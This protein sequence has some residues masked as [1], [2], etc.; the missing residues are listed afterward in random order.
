MKI[1]GF[2]H[3]EKMNIP[4][5]HD[6][7]SIIEG[8]I[9]TLKNQLADLQKR[10]NDLEK[11]LTTINNAVDTKPRKPEHSKSDT[12]ML[13]K[14]LFL[15]KEQLKRVTKEW[16]AASALLETYEKRLVEINEN[17]K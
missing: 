8:K 1:K 15:K 5:Q 11:K 7:A 12:R 4:R 14:D 9:Q 3:Q 13:E 16:D 17:P 6:E 10:S 2:A